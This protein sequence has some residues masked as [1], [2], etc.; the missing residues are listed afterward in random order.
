MTPPIIIDIEASGFGKGSYPIE[1]GYISRHG[2]QWCSLIMPSKDWTHWDSTAEQLH[3][4][5]RET[6]L[7]NGKDPVEIVLHLN[8]VFHHQTVYT[9]GWLQDYTWISQLFN[10]TNIAPLFK[11]ED[12]RNVLSPYQQSTW[13]ETKQS[14]LN[15]LQ[16]SR[17]RA[18]TDAKVLQMTWM[19]TVQNETAV[20]EQNVQS[21]NIY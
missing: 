10:L 5:S 11:L 4:I 7:R 20:N 8:D 19:K 16:L 17:H 9:D 6:L 12:L 3:R 2:H 13:H 18:S 15:D 14:I 21:H 1:V